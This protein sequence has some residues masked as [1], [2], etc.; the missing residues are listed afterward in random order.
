MSDSLLSIFMILGG[1]FVV[2]GGA[3]DWDWF[4]NHRRARLFVSLFGR[5]GT[6]VFYVILGAVLFLAGVGMIVTG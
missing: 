4:M 3:M 2:L 6:R 1:G 5:Q